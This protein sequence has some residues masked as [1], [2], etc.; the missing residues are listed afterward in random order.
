MSECKAKKNKFK[1]E[2]EEARLVQKDDEENVLLMVTSQ[3]EDQKETL[4]F[5]NIGCS[6]HMI[7]RKNWFIDLDMSI[8]TKVRFVDNS[9]VVVEGKGKD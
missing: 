4:W 7:G 3:M 6:N 8:K 9:V 2:E 5:L 1:K